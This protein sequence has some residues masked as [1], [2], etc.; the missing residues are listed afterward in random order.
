M[1]VFTVPCSDAVV[2][3]FQ[4][5]T[6]QRTTFCETGLVLQRPWRSREDAG[7]ALVRNHSGMKY[8]GLCHL[9]VCEGDDYTLQKSM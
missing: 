4:G 7:A 2:Y 9:T 6:R 5:I 8:S 1:T 3:Q